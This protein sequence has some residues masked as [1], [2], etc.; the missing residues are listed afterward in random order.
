MK[1]GNWTDEEL[2]KIL[3]DW[4]KG[5]HGRSGICVDEK[6]KQALNQIKD[7]IKYGSG[8][9]CYKCNRWVPVGLGYRCWYCK[10]SFCETCSK[11]HFRQHEVM[12]V[13]RTKYWAAILKEAK[14][15]IRGLVEEIVKEVGGKVK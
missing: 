9:K 10:N 2:V 7:Y 11:E 3:D 14:G 4:F 1:N 15:G 12:T 8:V 5:A 6:C 13:S